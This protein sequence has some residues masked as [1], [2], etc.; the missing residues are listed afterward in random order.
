MITMSQTSALVIGALFAFAAFMA[1]NR[2]ASEGFV[3]GWRE[4]RNRGN[5]MHGKYPPC[6]DI[7]G[8]TRTIY[9]ILEKAG[10]VQAHAEVLDA[11][12]MLL[13]QEKHMDRAC[14]NGML[15]RRVNELSPVT[16]KNGASL[17]VDQYS[18]RANALAKEFLV[19]I[20]PVL[21]R[22]LQRMLED[23]ALSQADKDAIEKMHEVFYSVHYPKIEG[24]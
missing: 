22:G 11:Y 21:E 15:L 5:P 8:A 3:S 9:D 4:H 13:C 12:S 6:Y 24:C 1:S 16:T 14:E 18:P 10:R 7:C 2:V 23:P 20:T 17:I 19:R